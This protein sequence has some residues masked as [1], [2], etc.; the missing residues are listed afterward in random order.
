MEDPLRPFRRKIR[1]LLGRMRLRREGESYRRRLTAQGLTVPDEQAVYDAL[2]RLHPAV[3]AKPKGDLT[4][5]AV[6]HHYNWEDTALLP[7]LER[8]GR[9][10]RYDWFR[11]FGVPD[12]DWPRRLRD[13]LNVDLLSFLE[14]TAG[15]ERI[16]V[17]FAYLSGEQV[18]GQTME[19]IRALGIPSVN[20][21]LNDKENFVGRIYRGQALGLRDIC[22][23]FSLCWTS[24]ED[25]LAKYVC[26][27]A[28]PVYLP[29]GA[30][31]EVHRPHA[32]ERTVDVSFVG[33]CY[34]NRRE[35]IRHLEERGFRVEAYGVGWPKGPL[36]TEEMV[37]MYSRSRINLGFGGVADHDDTYCLKGRDFE[38]PMS[39][40]LYLTEYHPELERVYDLEKEIVTYRD[41]DELTKKARFLLDNPAAA[42][43]VRRRGYERA[44][45]DHSWEKRLERVFTLMGLI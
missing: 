23:H 19:R 26:E 28:L 45:R 8:F 3:K 16:D 22:R 1:S 35:T 29:E 6:Y 20:L 25:A 21:S 11:R 14:E 31:P 43:A 15:Q 2:R 9:V 30:N 42:E 12:G 41:R 13:R 33:Q 27:G 17:I 32:V 38:V 24:T 34:G 7:A 36:S 10:L 5:L 39:G 4:I 37:L 18:T 44:R 40:G